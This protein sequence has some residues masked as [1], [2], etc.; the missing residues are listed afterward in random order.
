MVCGAVFTSPCVHTV[1]LSG[2]YVFGAFSWRWEGCERGFRAAFSSSVTNSCL[3][4]SGRRGLQAV[5][6]R[7]GWLGDVDDEEGVGDDA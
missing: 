3:L 4:D 2:V 7:L 1:A 5:G 6:G